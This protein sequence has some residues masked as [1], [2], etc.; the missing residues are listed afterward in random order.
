MSALDRQQLHARL[1]AMLDEI[2][3]GTSTLTSLAEHLS[4][5]SNGAF[6]AL[7]HNRALEETRDAGF[8]PYTVGAD[9]KEPVHKYHQAA[10]MVLMHE[11][12][13][14]MP[15]TFNSAAMTYD[16]HNMLTDKAA[17]QILSGAGTQENL[18]AQLKTSMRRRF[19][20]GLIYRAAQE[21]VSHETMRNR[22]GISMSEDTW[23]D[24]RGKGS[25]HYFERN[26]AAT[27]AGK[28]N[29]GWPTPTSD[30][31]LKAMFL[32][33]LGKRLQPLK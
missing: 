33:A 14:I 5:L 10:L 25:T 17:P 3:A 24:W 13:A 8:D 11:A 32:R 20:E 22:I 30:Q 9:R 12:S 7:V 27:A 15:N 2:D 19:V 29:A 6:A 1:D 16:L 28:A 21:G 23:D 31:E 4:A 26:Q 18:A